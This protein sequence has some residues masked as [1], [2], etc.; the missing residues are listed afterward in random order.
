MDFASEYPSAQ[1]IGTDLS[2]VQPTWIP[3]NLTFQ[4]DDFNLEWTFA[5]NHFD[6]IH[7]RWLVGT[8]ADWNKF[9]S[10][11]FHHLAPGGWFETH[12]MSAIIESDDGSVTPTSA[13]GQWGSIFISGGQK[14]G[15]PFTIIQDG[16]QK[17]GMEAAGFVDIQE[18]NFKMPIGD[19]P[20]DPDMKEIGLFSR[21]VLEGDPEGYV[22]FMTH[23]LGWSRDEILAYIQAVRKQVRG[24]KSRPFYRQR[25][26]WGRKPE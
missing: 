8:S 1:V 9:Y 6:Y 20:R 18:K 2:P 12:E 25:V 5:P 13:L 10:Q 24:R 26:V 7:T 21:A 15:I 19:W 11:A 16:T 23:S 3:P 14:M 4:I 17:K 22:L